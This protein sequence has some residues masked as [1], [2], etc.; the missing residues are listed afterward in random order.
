M[1]GEGVLVHV[2]C[3]VE[4]FLGDGSI[5]AGTR[6]EFLL[7]CRGQGIGCQEGE[8]L[9]GLGS[10]GLLLGGQRVL[11]QARQFVGEGVGRVCVQGLLDRGVQAQRVP[12]GFAGLLGGR[13]L[14]ARFQ[15][16]GR[17]LGLR[18]HLG[19]DEVCVFGLER[20]YGLG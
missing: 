5:V 9:L 10:R 16:F 4:A 18:V 15:E 2:G 8:D 13:R 20:G 12:E 17:L 3:L 1:L 14:I 7:G 11:A 6:V 19:R